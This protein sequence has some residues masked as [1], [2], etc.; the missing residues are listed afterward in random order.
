M[1]LYLA[2]SYKK[3]INVTVIEKITYRTFCDEYHYFLK[4]NL[5]MQ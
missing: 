1:L 4:E 3:G 2:K 5:L